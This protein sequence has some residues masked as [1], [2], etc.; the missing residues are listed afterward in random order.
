[1]AY[2]GQMARDLIPWQEGKPLCWDVTVICPLANSYL[3]S[4]TA[5]AGAV[6]EL[7]ATRKVAKYSAL[8][9]QY[10]FQPISCGVSWPHE[11]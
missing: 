1:M 5:S 8:E 10:I 6:A 4:A 11:L 3:Q 9:D 7:A 2:L